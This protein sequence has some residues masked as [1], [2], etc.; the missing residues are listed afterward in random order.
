M[1]DSKKF[2]IYCATPDSQV[3]TRLISEANVGATDPTTAEISLVS[4]KVYNG[5]VTK[6]D[7]ITQLMEVSV[8]NHKIQN[9]VYASQSLA[10][11]FGLTT[12]SVLPV[13]APVIV[14]Y[15]GASASPVILS[16]T[17]FVPAS[18]DFVKRTISGNREDSIAGKTAFIKEDEDMAYMAMKRGEQSSSDL[19]PG[20]LELS[21]G[22]GT[23]FRLLYNFAQLSASDAAKVEACLLN[24]MVRIVDNYF[25]HHTCGGDEFIWESGGYCTKENHFSSVLYEAEGKIKKDDELV[26]QESAEYVYSIPDAVEEPYTE[27]GRWR[28]SQYYGFLGDMIHRWVTSPTEVMSNIM[29]GSFR[30][31]QYR[32]WVGSDGTLMVQAA[33]GVQIEVTQHI[34][35][36]SILKAWNSP[37]FDM[38]K[39]LEDLNSEFLSV[40][41]SGPDWDDMKVAVWQLNYY[42]K[43]IALWKSLTRFRQLQEKQF[44]KIPTE[45][46]DDVPERTPTAGEDD[47]NSANPSANSPMPQESGHAILSMDTGGSIALVSG[48][49]TSMVMSNG[50]IQLACPGN[51]EV[52]AGGSVILQGKNVAITG[53]QNVAITSLFG[54]LIMKARTKLAALCEAGV[55]WLKGDASKDKLSDVPENP[56]GKAE[57][58]DPELREY[59]VVIDASEGKT[60]V[61]GATGVSIGTTEEESDIDIQTIGQDSAV[62]ITSNKD[63][64]IRARTG[65]IF[66]HCKDFITQATNIGFFGQ[67]IKLSNMAVIKKGVLHVRLIYAQLVSAFGSFIGRSKYVAQKEDMSD[68]EPD[69]ETAELDELQQEKVKA[70]TDMLEESFIKTEFGDDC[71]FKLSSWTASD[72]SQNVLDTTSLKAP[73]LVEWTNNSDDAKDTVVALDTSEESVRVMQA[74]RTQPDT[75]FPGSVVQVFKSSSEDSEKILGKAWEEDFSSNDIKSAK[76]MSLIPYTYIF[77]KNE[78]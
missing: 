29:E 64:D 69:L 49:S 46:S 11:I 4:G 13:G 3:T 37:D 53:A 12:T 31:G 65:T 10:S 42:S 50:S 71:V 34:V 77:R 73:F 9:C 21:S 8:G 41:G 56:L 36:P 38:E 17:G 23:S 2:S 48:G 19:L 44:C 57:D 67:L 62:T 25:V 78:N 54:S 68:Y 58:G 74:N 66:T 51:I 45:K 35:I 30:T 33:G 47:R 75:P 24:D 14:A 28:L 26:K 27:T 61:H 32:S 59:S 76:D 16:S 6:T 60:L 20:E 52:Q 15:T 55:L 40:W 63:V 22:L 43:Y 1:N 72:F 39:A 18:S 7:P 70:G 5:V